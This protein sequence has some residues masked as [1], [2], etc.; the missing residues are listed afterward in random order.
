[1]STALKP[2]MPL[3]PAPAGIVRLLAGWHWLECSVAVVAYILIMLLLMSDVVGREVVGPV[4][5]LVGVDVGATGV[6]GSQ[7]IALYAM[8]VGAFL[9]LGVATATGTHLLPR[10]GFGWLPKAWAPQIDRVADVL[11]GVLLCVTAWYGY[12]FVKSS[13]EA[14]LTVSVLEWPA[15]MIQ[16]VIPAGL[17]SAALRYF[18]FAAWPACRP[19][20]PEFQE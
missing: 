15:W 3:A 14:G 2:R 6:Y 7:K 19:T 4:L 13:M 16:S 9:G 17:L 12:V 20:P 10:V 1:M 8:V 11:T 18:I 5:R